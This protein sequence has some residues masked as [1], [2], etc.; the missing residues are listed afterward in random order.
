VFATFVGRSFS[1]PLPTN[2]KFPASGGHGLFELPVVAARGQRQRSTSTG[3]SIGAM[4]GPLREEIDAN[5]AA[6][7]AGLALATISDYVSDWALDPAQA[8]DEA[9]RWARRA[10]ELLSDIGQTNPAAG[11]RITLAPTKRVAPRSC[12]WI[13]RAQIAFYRRSMRLILL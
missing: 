9:E 5:F 2:R 6:P 8:P 3:R 13:L 11:E 1:T 12:R 10:V 7:H 4:P